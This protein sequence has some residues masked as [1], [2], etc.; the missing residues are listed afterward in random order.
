[1]PETP[2]FLKVLLS[3][4]LP[5]Y[6]FTLLGQG[7]CQIRIELNDKLSQAFFYFKHVETNSFKSEVCTCTRQ[8]SLGG[9]I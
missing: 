5:G 9:H 4:L 3:L 1:M 2:N 6:G 7:P 8:A